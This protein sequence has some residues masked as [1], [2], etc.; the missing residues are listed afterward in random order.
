[1]ND[2]EFYWTIFHGV[3]GL[4]SL[5]VIVYLSAK[6]EKIIKIYAEPIEA[7]VNIIEHRY[8]MQ[9]Y[10]MEYRIPRE[11]E[12]MRYAVDHTRVARERFA[13]D[14]AELA[15]LEEVDDMQQYE[16]ILRLSLDLA[17]RIS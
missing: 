10:Q 8:R 6:S 1:M 7:I 15:T 16:K 14:L 17:V 12:D 3:L 5:M 13:R 9:R 11:H 2:Y 4:T